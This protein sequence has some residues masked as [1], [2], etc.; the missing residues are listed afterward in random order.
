MFSYF[1]KI[2]CCYYRYNVFLYKKVLGKIMRKSSYVAKLG[3][4]SCAFFGLLT[5]EQISSMMIDKEELCM[6]IEDRQE[7]VDEALRI[8]VANKNKYRTKFLLECG[9]N[10][11][12]ANIFSNTYPGLS[13]LGIAIIGGDPGLVDFLITKYKAKVNVYAYFYD[14]QYP[15]HLVAGLT[16]ERYDE[17]LKIAGVLLKHGAEMESRDSSGC[18]PFIYA[19][20][21]GRLF[22]TNFLMGAGAAVHA[23]DSGNWTALHYAAKSGNPAL[24]TILLNYGLGVYMNAE[25]DDGKTPLDIATRFRDLEDLYTA[26]RFRDDDDHEPLWDVAIRLGYEKDDDR[27]PPLDVI[28]LDAIWSQYRTIADQ[29]RKSGAKEKEER[30]L[31]TSV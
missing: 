20:K 21:R 11:D 30:Y 9:A 3:M 26:I 14:L 16:E 23:T 25:N 13:P 5:V 31:R 22:L 28:Q 4:L 24:V 17:A 15:L 6:R 12:G 19:A 27:D 29:L 2:N 7:K 8:A 18:T 1:F 10:I